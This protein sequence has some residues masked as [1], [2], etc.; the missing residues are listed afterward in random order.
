MSFMKKIHLLTIIG[1]I[2]CVSSFGQS[3]KTDSIFRK[4]VNRG[5]YKQWYGQPPVHT[6]G[7]EIEGYTYLDKRLHFS[8]DSLFEEIIFKDWFRVQL[9]NICNEASKKERF[10]TLLSGRWEINDDTL[11]LKY[12]TKYIYPEIEFSNCF[13]LSMYKKFKCDILPLCSSNYDINRFFTFKNEE[14]C[15]VA[16]NG[17]CYR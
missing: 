2:L 16:E 5:Y 8:P 12:T 13:Y 7:A 17:E 15:E 4:L 3:T 14:L 1:Q 9:P 10:T 11:H 6:D